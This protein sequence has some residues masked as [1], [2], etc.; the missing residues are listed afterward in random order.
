MRSQAFRTIVSLALGTCFA[1]S[2]GAQSEPPVR[3]S[4]DAE[5]GAVKVLYH[6][7]RV[8]AAGTGSE[9]D[10]V[11]Q[12]GQEILFPFERLTAIFTVAGD[13]EIRFLYQSLELD[14]DV[15]FRKDVTIDGTVFAAQTPMRLSYGFPFYRATYQYRFLRG[16]G[17][18]LAAGAALQLRDASIKFA[19]LDGKQL[20]V[21]QNLG[22]VPALAL[23]GRLALGNGLWTSFDATGIYASSAFFNGASFTFEGSIL[24]ASLRLG[25]TLRD[26]GDVYL[27]LRFLGGTADGS[28]GYARAEWTNSVSPT[29]SNHLATASLTV[30]TTLRP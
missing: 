19:S 1:A 13:H 27:N 26:I 30:G 25:S 21:N 3:F 24:D 16:E 11:N 2:L 23:S 8:G 20:V 22:L 29:T 18:W 9:F 5:L 10:F 14:S 17:S 6:T 12:G 15:V 7:Y 4:V 28:S